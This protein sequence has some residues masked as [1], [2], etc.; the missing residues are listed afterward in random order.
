VR[1]STYLFD[2]AQFTFNPETRRDVI[3]Y[4]EYRGQVKELV[5]RENSRAE[6]KERHG[7]FTDVYLRDIFRLAFTI[8]LSS[9]SNTTS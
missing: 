5:H 6:P 9:S 2:A 8:L 1:I 4:F 3:R 7:K